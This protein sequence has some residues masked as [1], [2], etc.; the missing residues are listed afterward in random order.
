MI[1]RALRIIVMLLV[2]LGVVA[3][4][5][6]MGAVRDLNLIVAGE[7][8]RA[9]RMENEIVLLRERVARLEPRVSGLEEMII[10]SE[11]GPTAVCEEER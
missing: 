6:T 8:S 3:L 10:F 4:S 1:G 7:D 11:R 9:V 5:T 2:A